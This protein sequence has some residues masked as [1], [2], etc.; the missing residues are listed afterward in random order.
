LTALMGL[1]PTFKAKTE[2]PASEPPP[3]EA[4]ANQPR[5]RQLEDLQREAPGKEPAS[6]AP[7]KKRH[8]RPENHIAHVA[9]LAQSH[10]TQAPF[11][12]LA[13]RPWSRKGRA[14]H[15]RSSSRGWALLSSSVCC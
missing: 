4:P 13:P 2:T 7:A 3:S 5:R 1:K 11:L 10:H 9:G 14:R 6:E 12:W 15:H 8:S